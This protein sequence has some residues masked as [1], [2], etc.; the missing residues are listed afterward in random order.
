M[1]SHLNL[2]SFTWVGALVPAEELKGIVMYIFLHEEPRHW[3]L[4]EVKEAEWSLFPKTRN[5]H[6][7]LLYPREPHKV[8]LCFTL[9]TLSEAASL[10]VIQYLKFKLLAFVT[11]NHVSLSKMSV[12]IHHITSCCIPF[13]ENDFHILEVLLLLF[14]H[15]SCLTLCNPMDCKTSPNAFFLYATLPVF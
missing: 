15:Q 10:S 2:P 14:N 6:R 11:L 7:T 4:G 1:S 3:N 12:P 8:L 5:R 13:L 9:N